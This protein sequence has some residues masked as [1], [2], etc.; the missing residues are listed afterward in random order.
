MICHGAA[1]LERPI[2]TLDNAVVPKSATAG[3]VDS[4]KSASISFFAGGSYVVSEFGYAAPAAVRNDQLSLCLQ[5]PSGPEWDGPKQFDKTESPVTIQQYSDTL[6][7]QFSN[8]KARE[9][10]RLSVPY[11]SQ[12]SGPDTIK[13]VA[14]PFIGSPIRSQNH[15]NLIPFAHYSS[16]Y[17]DNHISQQFLEFLLKEFP[18]KELKIYSTFESINT[19]PHANYLEISLSPHTK[20]MD[21][22]LIDPL[23]RFSPIYKLTPLCFFVETSAQQ[24]E[25]FFKDNFP[26]GYTV[27]FKHHFRG[28]QSA[29]NFVDC[30]RF[31]M[32]Y[33]RYA[34]KGRSPENLTALDIYLGKQFLYKAEKKNQELP[35]SK[36]FLD[37]FSLCFSQLLGRPLSRGC[38]LV[39][40]YLLPEE[41]GT[42]LG[43][44]MGQPLHALEASTT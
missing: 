8:R 17:K 1:A 12:K 22:L 34:L 5:D 38:A 11:C 23:G 43:G 36:S 24:G 42:A 16:A 14:L 20:E 10:I 30:E 4:L 7:Q 21:V 15:I 13:I 9:R 33:W 18:E 28:D 29:L 6:S 41:E 35:S 19:F 26:K 40:R 44:D 27:S 25:K 2:E 39:L 3:W 32:I 31:A 37:R